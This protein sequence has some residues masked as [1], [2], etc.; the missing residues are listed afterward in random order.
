[1]LFYSDLLERKI[2]K[3]AYFYIENMLV[4]K[5]HFPG[6]RIKISKE[7]GHFSTLLQNNQWRNIT[8]KQGTRFVLRSVIQGRKAKFEQ[9][10]GHFLHFYKISNEETTHNIH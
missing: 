3:F 8:Y 2:C 4:S 10:K 5:F 6:L 9:N 1:M 7:Q